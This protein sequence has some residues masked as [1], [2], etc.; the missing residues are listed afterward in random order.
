MSGEH[1][2]GPYCTVNRKCMTYQRA[3]ENYRLHTVQFST[4]IRTGYQQFLPEV[5]LEGGRLSI[6]EAATT[7]V[8][9]LNRRLVS[10]PAIL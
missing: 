10:T 5:R 6:S 4:A 8:K 9:P 1:R 3:R 7:A 2:A